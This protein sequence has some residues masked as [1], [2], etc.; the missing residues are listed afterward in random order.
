MG[1]KRMYVRNVSSHPVL[2]AERRMRTQHSDIGSGFDSR[3]NSDNSN[4][5]NNSENTRRAIDMVQNPTPATGTALAGTA[6]S[7]GRLRITRRGR[8]VV[9]ALVTI[10][11]LAGALVFAAN[12]VATATETST[13][14]SFQQ[15]TVAAGQSLWQLAATLAPSADPRDVVSDIVHLNQLHGTDV[16]PGQRLAIPRQY[17]H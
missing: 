1:R 9:A 14:A 3:G 13:S 15:V 16:H 12:G 6:A 4:S 17:A 8:A 10:P 2:P 11:L 7:V 5:S